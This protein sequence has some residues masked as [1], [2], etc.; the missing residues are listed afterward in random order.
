MKY[1]TEIAYHVLDINIILTNQERER[2]KPMFITPFKEMV[3]TD[4]LG[5]HQE[6]RQR[7]LIAF[8]Q[9]NEI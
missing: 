7:F 8:E 9:T 4:E 5:I 1:K 2:W 3:T 6:E